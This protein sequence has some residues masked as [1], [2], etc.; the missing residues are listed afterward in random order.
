MVSCEKMSSLLDEEEFSLNPTDFGLED[1][2]WHLCPEK[3]LQPDSR[4]SFEDL[5]LQI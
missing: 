1:I 2:N 3:T 4:P 5:R